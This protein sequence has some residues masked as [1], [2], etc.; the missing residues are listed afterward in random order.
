MTHLG[1]HTL[2]VVVRRSV[3]VITLPRS[4]LLRLSHSAVTQSDNDEDDIE[5][6]LDQT[7]VPKIE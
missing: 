2:G 5:D 3:I 1:V 6:L 7:T 4:L